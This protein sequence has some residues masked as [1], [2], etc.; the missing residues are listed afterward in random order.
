[1]TEKTRSTTNIVTV[2][3]GEN[4]IDR[5]LKTTLPTLLAP[6]NIPTFT[7]GR[8]CEYRIY[9]TA[10]DAEILSSAPTILALK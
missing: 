9:T 7:A 5:Y 4:F 8:Q 2:L 1:M 6:G 3:W 10:K